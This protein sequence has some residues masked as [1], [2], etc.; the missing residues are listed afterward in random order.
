MRRAAHQLFDDPKVWDDPLALRILKPETIA[1]LQSK[2]AEQDTLLS[3]A[4]RA[5]LAARSR[6]AE[7]ELAVSIK[8][9]VRQY[10]V[11]GAGLDTSAYRT[12]AANGD[13]R[14][15]EVDHPATQ[16]W[17]RERLRAA[18]IPVPANLTFVPVDFE[19]QRL[20]EQLDVVGFQPAPTF[21]SWLGVT[22]YLTREAF[23]ATMAFISILPLRTAVVFDYAVDPSSL[24]AFQQAAARALAARV[25]AAGEPFR[26]FFNPSDLEY[27]LRALGFSQ[28]ENLDCDQINARYFSDR[29]DG[30]QVTGRLGRLMSA[31][32]L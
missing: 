15:F 12:P 19:R 1:D 4:L 9:G 8:R 23:D 26:L 24:D 22:P 16:A 13:L 18:G 6:F 27:E 30:L 3:R 17:K 21:F 2:P 28:A 32:K 25:E 10:V 7:D 31:W 14:V 20:A 11:L 29:A 5:F